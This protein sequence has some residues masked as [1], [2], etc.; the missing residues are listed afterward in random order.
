ML[1]D[2]P[3]LAAASAAQAPIQIR[4]PT[5]TPRHTRFPF[6]A[7]TSRS[8]VAPASPNDTASSHAAACQIAD[9]NNRY[10]AEQ[11]YDAE[12]RVVEV[13]VFDGRANADEFGVV[14]NLRNGIP[15]RRL[16]T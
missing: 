7:A 10:W 15:S 16:P 13:K 6:L 4:S 3:R 14:S 1:G 11:G 12:A 8:H 9:S 5:R 2:I